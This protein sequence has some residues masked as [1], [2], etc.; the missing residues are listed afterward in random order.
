MRK[1]LVLLLALGALAGA[2]AFLPLRGATLLER[3]AVAPSTRD[4]A[5]RG[6]A[7]VRASLSGRTVAQTGAPAVARGPEERHTAADQAALDR[8]VTERTRR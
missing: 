2:A 6:V 1:L 3:W 7:E 5:S 8:L 4:F